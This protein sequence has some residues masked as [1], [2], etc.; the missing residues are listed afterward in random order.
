M[1]AFQMTTS[2]LGL[3]LAVVIVWLIRRDDLYIRHALFWL[4]VAVL[5]AV[6]GL[7]PGSIDWMGDLVGIRYSPALILLCA[8][9]VLFVKTLHTDVVNTRLEMELRHLKQSVALLEAERAGLRVGA[10]DGVVQESVQGLSADD[11]SDDTPKASGS[12]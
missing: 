2:L 1:H 9:L 11:A 7:W 4:F 6:L 12:A 8:V 5:A 3:G 10:Q